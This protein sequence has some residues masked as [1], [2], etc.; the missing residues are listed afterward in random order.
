MRHD[1][2]IAVDLH[3]NI[4]DV[5]ITGQSKE[6]VWRA[7]SRVAKLCSYFGLQDAPRKLREPSQT[8]GAWARSVVATVGGSVTKFVTDE[9]WGKTQRCIRWPW[10]ASKLEIAGDEMECWFAHRQGCGKDPEGK[11]SA[12]AGGANS[13]ILDLRLENV[14]GN[15]AIS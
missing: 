4:D 13:G 2:I 9:R 3:I 15:G 10:I 1:K 6:L 12:Q 11:D 14:Y 5:R 7:R 8:P